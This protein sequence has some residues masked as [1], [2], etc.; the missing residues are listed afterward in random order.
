MLSPLQWTLASFCCSMAGANVCDWDWGETATII[1]LWGA[2]KSGFPDGSSFTCCSES[3]R[4]RAGP[5][6]DIECFD[7]C[8]MAVIRLGT[9]HCT[10]HGPV[11]SAKACHFWAFHYISWLSVWLDE[12]NLL[13]NLPTSIGAREGEMG[14]K[15]RT[16]SRSRSLS[17]MVTQ[18]QKGLQKNQ[19]H[20][21]EQTFREQKSSHMM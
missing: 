9:K 19:N 6:M 15:M 21:K 13:S 18:L 12:H 16:Y 1:L 4:I 7:G 17:T 3:C 10:C 5:R 2:G 8:G 11:D 20:L 14:H